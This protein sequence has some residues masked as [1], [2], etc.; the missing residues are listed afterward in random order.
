MHLFIHSSIKLKFFDH[1]D[2]HF[3]QDFA[4]WGAACYACG[5]LCCFDDA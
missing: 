4:A 1:I 3:D 2:K 5:M